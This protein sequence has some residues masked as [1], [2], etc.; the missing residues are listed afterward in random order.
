MTDN[1]SPPPGQAGRARQVLYIEDEPLNVVLMEETFRDRPG[2]ALQVARDGE[3]GI[4][5]AREGQPDLVMIDMHLPDMGGLDVLR[6]LRGR[7]DTAGL[8]CVALSADAMR[9]QV[10]AALQAGFDDYWTKPVDLMGLLSGIERLLA[11][12]GHSAAAPGASP[13]DPPRA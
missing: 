7:P 1:G 11:H 12:R 5:M 2:W 8:L 6:C 13:P 4:A 9:E 10:Q 3:S